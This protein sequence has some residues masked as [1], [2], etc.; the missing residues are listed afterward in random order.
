M[1][2]STALTTTFNDLYLGPAQT[3]ARIR[4]RTYT[5]PSHLRTGLKSIRRLLSVAPH[6]EPQM[7]IRT[8]AFLKVFLKRLRQKWGVLFTEL[9][10]NGKCFPVSVINFAFWQSF[11]Y[12]TGRVNAKSYDQI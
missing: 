8:P 4:K 9:R 10:L 1:A 3:R 7:P 6:K 2:A 11:S 12:A 5:I